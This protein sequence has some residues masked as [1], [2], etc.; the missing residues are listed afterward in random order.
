[1][2]GTEFIA[3]ILK[4]EG[5]DQMTCFPS[6]ALIEAAAIDVSIGTPVH[7]EAEAGGI[8]IVVAA[9][10]AASQYQDLVRSLAVGGRA[11]WIGAIGGVVAIVVDAVVAEHTAGLWR[12]TDAEAVRVGAIR[13]A[14]TVVVLPVVAG[15]RQL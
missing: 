8:V 13:G 5:V 3:R 11:A 6:N 14:V 9:I 12:I 4:S 2:N 15:S 10:G 1:M 7:A